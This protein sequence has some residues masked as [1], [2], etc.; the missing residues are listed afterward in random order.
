MMLRWQWPWALVAALLIA[1][2]VCLTIVMVSSH[3]R[4]YHDEAR[5]YGVQDDLETE[6]AGA[7]MRVWRR[8]NRIAVALLACALV[9]SCILVGRPAHVDAQDEQS[10]NRDIILCLDV[11][12]STLPYDHQVLS[13]YLNLLQHFKGERI[14]LSIFNSSSRTV[15]PLTDDY[16]MVTEQLTQANDMLK[17]VQTQDDIDKMSDEQY[18]QIADWLEGTQNRKNA[19]SLIGDG[20]VGCA[21]M[22]PGFAYSKAD[23]AQSRSREASIVLAT[24]NVVSGSP[25]YSL[26]QALDLTSQA[27]INVD[28][29]YSGPQSSE[30]DATTNEMRQLIERHGGLF[31]TQSNS[32]SID[33]LV[34]EID[35]RRSHEAQAQSQ[36]ALTDVPGWW[37]LAVAI[38]LAGW[39]VMAW[40]LKR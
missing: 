38:L 20:L 32:A 36:T 29:L 9:L 31:L 12:G 14:G 23:T 33:E 28:G 6:H 17:G 39:L 37:T 7:L 22:L 26:A 5:I 18:Q 4:A 11:S 8:L 21:A 3:R 30:G 19:T 1:A 27:G 15:F 16:A 24:D 2:L 10:S 25:T 34:R 13:T 40:R 35:G